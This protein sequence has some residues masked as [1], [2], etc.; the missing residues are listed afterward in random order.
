MCF[1]Y[2][3]LKYFGVGESRLVL[4]CEPP[5]S[6]LL[7]C[8]HEP[9]CPIQNVLIGKYNSVKGHEAKTRSTRPHQVAGD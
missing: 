4:V 5:A 6:S 7:D 8:R 1:G 9:P 3:M 2:P